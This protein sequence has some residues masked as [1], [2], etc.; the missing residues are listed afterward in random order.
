MDLYGVLITYQRPDALEYSL[1]Q[2][3]TQSPRQ[4]KK[5]VVV[6]NERSQVTHDLVS[7]FSDRGLAVDYLP[8]RDNIGPAGGR[9]LGAQHLLT[10]ASDDDWV[11]F[12]DD[13]RALPRPST[14]SELGDFAD[15]MLAHD[16][17]TAGVGL[18]G[19]RVDLRRVRVR[20]PAAHELTGPVR[21]D[22]LYSNRFP[23][24]RVA[25]IRR[26]GSDDPRFFW[27]WEDTEYCL[28]LGELGHALYMHGALWSELREKMS[29]PGFQ[30]VRIRV[31][32]PESRR[33]YSLRNLIR[34]LIERG[35]YLAA[36]RVALISGLVKPLV[37]I[38]IAPRHAVRNLKLNVSA[39]RDGLTGRMGCT[40]PMEARRLPLRT[41][42]VN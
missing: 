35:H 13:R 18:A 27:G 14:L 29:T 3:H 39:L 34:I 10:E 12:F 6:D 22:T 25:V 42:E 9:A 19:A 8:A 17:A 2:I 24:F 37:N 32:E 28:R 38:P 20:M 26:H 4:L 21:V 31:E 33:Y 30:H 40:M 11:V 36:F 23:T 1:Q 15:Q 16:P 41:F 5:L 7:D